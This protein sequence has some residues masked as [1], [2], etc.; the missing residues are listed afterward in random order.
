MLLGGGSV[1]LV[2]RSISAHNVR[3]FSV[4]LH[5]VRAT[6]ALISRPLRASARTVAF[7]PAD[8]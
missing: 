6:V 7:V 1:S 3:V 5:D 8:T 4:R 2:G